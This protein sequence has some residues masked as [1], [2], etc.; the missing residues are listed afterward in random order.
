MME[1]GNYTDPLVPVVI[2]NNF[3]SVKKILES[4]NT[5]KTIL[6]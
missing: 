3:D 2:F 5:E 4:V 1:S 6:R